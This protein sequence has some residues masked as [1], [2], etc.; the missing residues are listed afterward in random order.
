MNSQSCGIIDK[1]AVKLDNSGK[2]TKPVL[3][4]DNVARL[5]NIAEDISDPPVLFL[6]TGERSRSQIMLSAGRF[7]T[8]PE[9][10]RFPV[11]DIRLPIGVVNR[12]F[13]TLG[14]T[15]YDRSYDKAVT[16]FAAS[17][18]GMRMRGDLHRE[19]ALLFGGLTGEMSVCGSFDILTA[20]NFGVR[21]GKPQVFAFVLTVAGQWLLCEAAAEVMHA[22]LADSSPEV[23]FAGEMFIYFE[24]GKHWLC[25]TN[26]SGTYRPGREA[27]DAVQ[28]LLKEVLGDIEVEGLDVADPRIKT[29]T[30][31]YKG[32]PA[33]MAHSIHYRE[34]GHPT[35]TTRPGPGLAM[36][37]R[38]SS[39]AGS[40]TIPVVPTVSN[41]VAIPSQQVLRVSL[42]GTGTGPCQTTFAA[43]SSPQET[44]C[45][46]G[47]GS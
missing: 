16:L 34:R 12:H 6:L 5:T 29:L 2:I 18:D 11:W 30:V 47:L 45:T 41:A 46:V 43:P 33:H 8:D 39:W 9:T 7:S 19:H 32:D 10:E 4:T 13:A 20:L 44:V 27:L 23:L 37:R 14:P 25:I 26:N 17:V 1:V 31:R 28:G 3:K 42:M 22:A 15:S 35:L 24:A 40:P 36:H 21:Y 38:V